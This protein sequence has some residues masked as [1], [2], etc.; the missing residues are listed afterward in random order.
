MRLASPD[1]L[2]ALLGLSLTACVGEIGGGGRPGETDE[3]DAPE[4]TPAAQGRFNRVSHSFYRNAIADVFEVDAGVID[5]L[6]LPE[7]PFRFDTSGELLPNYPV[8]SSYFENSRAVAEAVV[9]SGKLESLAPCDVSD[10]QVC[11][12]QLIE[13]RGMLLYGR[14]LTES[15][16]T[17]LVALAEAGPHEPDTTAYRAQARVA[18]EALLVQ[19]AFLL[20]P[21]L[22][23]GS[24][25]QAVPREPAEIAR[26]LSRRIWLS[27]PSREL[28]ERAEAG[29]LDSPDELRATIEQMFVDPRG[30]RWLDAFIAQFLDTDAYKDIVQPDLEL[31]PELLATLRAE[32]V[33][34]ARHVIVEEEGSMAE[35]FTTPVAFVNRFNAPLYDLESDSDDLVR[36]DLDPAARAGFFTQSGQLASLNYPGA[37]HPVKRGARVLNELL[38]ADIKMKALDPTEKDSFDTA[39]VG[40]TTR[41]RWDS[42]TLGGG[43]CSSCHSIINPI[44]YAFEGFGPDGRARTSE[45]G[46]PIDTSGTFSLATSDDAV[47]GLSISFNGAVDL[48]NQ[49]AASDMMADC[50]TRTLSE[51]LVGQP[52]KPASDFET[53]RSM[54]L[55]DWM[56][57]E[58]I[59]ATIRPVDPGET[60]AD[61][62][63]CQ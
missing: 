4:N 57:E 47:A 29:G 42:A 19:P 56:I 53:F 24:D 50:L 45:N 31:T 60:P 3:S 43:S 46:L 21:E 32:A 23:E 30:T 44:G 41:E 27:V 5:A 12:R 2:V 18:I 1:L 40:E 13:E 28:V 36:V 33:L 6:E 20:Q 16:V 52:T 63:A 9:T 61:M 10:T 11:I 62:E 8:L 15:E 25:P 7:E 59:A 55:L 49:L 17:K 58:Q 48:A 22:S 26:L 51:Y 39:F 34:F 37:T 14:R 54:S 35:L 38:C